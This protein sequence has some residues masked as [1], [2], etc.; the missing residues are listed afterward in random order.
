[1]PVESVGAYTL[2][3]GECEARMMQVP[4]ADVHCYSD[5]SWELWD[6]K[7]VLREPEHSIVIGLGNKPPEDVPAED[8]IDE[9]RNRIAGKEPNKLD[10]KG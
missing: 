3:R 5:A 7:I 10:K 1:M 4:G 6:E 2:P 9:A 8:H